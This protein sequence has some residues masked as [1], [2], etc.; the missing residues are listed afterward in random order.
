M[1]YTNE[2]WFKV[3]QRLFDSSIW[4]EDP[5]TRIV[6]LTLLALAQEPSN[7]AHGN[8]SVI[9][10]PGNLRRKALV[11]PEE[12]ERAIGRLLAPDPFSRTEP[13]R[14]RLE[15]LENGYRV[16]AFELYNSR[17]RYESYIERAR[18]GG[19]ARVE[20]AERGE[21]GKFK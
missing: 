13:G 9:I 8:G 11:K 16:P 5:V 4:E 12:F 1:N 18:K 17:E 6:W 15:L 21:D 3:H 19:K 10:T 2:R 14:P 7:L 20:K